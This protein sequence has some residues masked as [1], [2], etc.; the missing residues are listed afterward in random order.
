MNQKAL[1]LGLK[2]SHFVTPHGLDQKEHYTTAFELA[3]MADYALKIPK[4]KEIVGTKTYTITISNT[5]RVIFNTNEL[6]GNLNGVYGVKT[7]FTNG[8]GRCLVTAC[9]RNDLDIITVVLGADTKKMRTQDSVQL[10]NYIYQNYQTVNIEEIVKKQFEEW[11]Q[12]NEK[13]IFIH[14]GKE[15]S[16]KLLLEQMPYTKMAI[17]NTEVDNITVEISN[18]FYLKAPVAENQ[19]IGTLKVKRKEEVLETFMIRNQKQIEKKQI[20]DYFLEFLSL[21]P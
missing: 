19:I 9:K 12:I 21:I 10:I 5:P 13:R 8:A 17:K 18:F 2:N 20:F 7:G 6:L 11:K 14:K 1:Q 3:R 4:F 15:N 16:I